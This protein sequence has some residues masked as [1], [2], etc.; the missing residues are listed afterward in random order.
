MRRRMRAEAPTASKTTLFSSLRAKCCGRAMPWP[1]TPRC[2]SCQA[3][4]SMLGSQ[5]RH[6]CGVLLLQRLRRTSRQSRY[7]SSTTV[8]R[9]ALLADIDMVSSVR[10][11]KDSRQRCNPRSFRG[12]LTRLGNNS[13]ETRPGQILSILAISA[14]A[15]PCRGMRMG[16]GCGSTGSPIASRLRRNCRRTKPRRARPR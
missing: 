2:L 12:L 15:K 3:S 11:G 9:M 13:Y 16:Q 7:D 1:T 5:L 8:R 10:G 6:L 4:R 14:R